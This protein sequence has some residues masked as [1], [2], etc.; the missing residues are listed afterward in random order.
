MESNDEVELGNYW[1][2]FKRSWWMIALGMLSMTALA[3]V[4]LPGQRNF[5]QSDV[6]VL[7]RPGQADVGPPNDPVN[8]D[9][10]IGIAT[11]AL[12]GTRV[13][14]D[15]IVFTAENGGS[16]DID[17]EV[18]T[19]ALEVIC[20][21]GET[22]FTSCDSQILQFSYLG[23]TAEEA[24]RVVQNSADEYLSWRIERE[25]LLRDSQI[26]ELESQLAELGVRITNERAVLDAAIDEADGGNSSEIQRS[27]VRLRFLEEENLNLQLLLDEVQEVAEVGS[28][29]GEPSIATAEATGIPR[30]FT[31]LAGIIMGFLVGA[32]AAVLTDRL[33]RRISGPVETELD[34]GVPVLGNIPRITEDNPAMVTASGPETAGAES[35][36]RLAAA[37]LAPRNGFVVDSLAITGATDKEGRTTTAINLAVAI[38]QT[39]RNVLLCLLYTSPSPRDS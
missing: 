12:I 9:R 25:Q 2:I 7:L 11:S 23:N 10:E 3:L 16:T 29:L 8:E 31:L 28:L 20:L 38:S 37:V 6:T 33:D 18:W 35:F 1:R 22:T 27:E 17:I 34:L 36:R 5:F 14:E 19:E 30:L 32:L 13:I 4:F 26:G 24:T 39:G 21:G 15:E